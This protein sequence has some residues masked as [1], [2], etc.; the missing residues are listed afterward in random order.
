MDVIYDHFLAN[1]KDIFGEGTLKRFTQTVYTVL[2][3]HTAQL[4]D[5]FVQVLFYMKTEDW[6]YH[7]KYEQGIEKSLRGLVRRA[8]YLSESDTAYRLFLEHYVDL[9]DCYNQFFP[10]VKQ[11]AKQ[12]LEKLLF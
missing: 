1:D 5:I 7:Y 10:D 3:E 6:L 9:R 12:R 8:A 4:P 11:F 2:E